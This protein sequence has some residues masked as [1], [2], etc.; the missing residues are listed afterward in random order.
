MAC[1]EKTVKFGLIR[2]EIRIAIEPTRHLKKWHR[3]FRTESPWLVGVGAGP[4]LRR[5]ASIALVVS[6]QAFFTTEGTKNNG[7]SSSAATGNKWSPF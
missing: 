4:W 3:N 5:V 2:G 1:T 6:P 7:G